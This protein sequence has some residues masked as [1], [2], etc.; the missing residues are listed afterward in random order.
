MPLRGNVQVRVEEFTP[1][2]ATLVT[3]AGHPLASSESAT[4]LRDHDNSHLGPDL[5]SFDD[6][7]VCAIGRRTVAS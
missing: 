6:A 3:V 4:W 2:S 5:D 7:L 1:R